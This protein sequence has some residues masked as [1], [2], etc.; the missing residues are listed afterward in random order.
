MANDL[1]TNRRA[2]F[3]YEIQQTFEAG[4]ELVGTE[5][6]SLRDNGGSLQE[7]YAVVESGELWLR[8]MHIAAYRYGNLYNHDETRSRKL[9]LHKREIEQIHTMVQQK[10]HT[11][12][13]LG[14]YLVR[15][16]AK[17]KLALC[18]GKKKHDKRRAIREREDTRAIERA[19]KR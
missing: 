3:D 17:V 6:K 1:V 7:A 15:G 11:L 10:G 8:Q 14:M 12:I 16:V 5:I 18:V 9:L 13:P 2:L 19:L 4:I